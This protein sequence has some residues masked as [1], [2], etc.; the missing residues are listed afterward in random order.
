MRQFK[1]HV[2][3]YQLSIIL[4]SAWIIHSSVIVYI[5]LPKSCYL[6]KHRHIY[7]NCVW[8]KGFGADP[9]TTDMTKNSTRVNC[10]KPRIFHICFLASSIYLCFL[11]LF[12]AFLSFSL[13]FYFSLLFSLPFP[14]SVVPAGSPSRGGDVAVCVCDIKQPSLPTPFYPVFVSASV[15][16]AI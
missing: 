1:N 14:F 10:S 8:L 13:F 7:Y 16:M 15:F 9:R 5:P 3:T 6:Y 12:I 2:L 4:L 11:S